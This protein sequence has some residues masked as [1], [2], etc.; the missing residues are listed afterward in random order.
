M[1]VIFL[2]VAGGYRQPIFQNATPNLAAR[3]TL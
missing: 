1:L 3:G 2:V